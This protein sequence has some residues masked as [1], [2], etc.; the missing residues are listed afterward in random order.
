MVKPFYY[1][2]NDH[3][4]ESLIKSFTFGK[5]EL[6]IISRITL[7]ILVMGS[8]S[9]FGG[10]IQRKFGST[11]RRALSV[12]TLTQFHFLFY[13]SRC[14]P[15]TFALVT[16]LLALTYWLD[17]KWRE[18]IIAVAFTVVVIRADT[19][20]LFGWIILYE[21]FLTKQLN[22][23]YL[24]KIGIPSGLLSLVFTVL[25][26]SYMWGHWTWPE[27]DGLLLNVIHNQSHQWGTQPFFW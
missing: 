21:V 3:K 1:L 26:D 16:V 20:L 10:A 17:K 5:F 19:V 27:G 22:I 14:L 23:L 6:Q 4:G 11:T 8:F 13:S 12:L 15:N 18:F 25:F 24:F 7:S 2:I 9:M